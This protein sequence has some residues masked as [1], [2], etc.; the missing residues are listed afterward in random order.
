[1]R[2]GLLH[3]LLALRFPGPGGLA[4]TLFPHEEI[5]G[6]DRCEYLHR[7]TLARF[8][9]GRALYLHHFVGADWSR[10]LHDHP[11]PFYVL[12]LWG[13]YI[14]ETPAAAVYSP[15]FGT[16]R[17]RVY[18]APFL[19]WFP[20]HHIHRLVLP[21]DAN[22]EPIPAWTLVFVGRPLRE[23]GFWMPTAVGAYALLS[24]QWVPWFEYVRSRR[25]DDAKD[26]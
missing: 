19:R 7:W 20:A 22:N 3:R 18:R 23:W 4:C 14:E 17:F 24:W 6:A 10:D 5:N 26:C 11:K 8:P 21:V 15:L 25:A 13:R 2:Y 16:H 1:M 9:G 12:G